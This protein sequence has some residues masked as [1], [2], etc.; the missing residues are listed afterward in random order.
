MSLLYKSNKDVKTF[1]NITS[2]SGN[3]K[4]IIK[5]EFSADCGKFG[6]HEQLCDFEFDPEELLKIF[7]NDAEQ[8]II[9]NL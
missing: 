4:I 3:G 5:F 7:V 6:T 8:K 2:M 1:V 9:S